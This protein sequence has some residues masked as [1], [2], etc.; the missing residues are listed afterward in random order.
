M[1]KRFQISII[2]AVLVLTNV[3]TA[4]AQ[5]NIWEGTSVSHRVELTPYLVKG[6]TPAPAVIVCPGGSYFWHDMVN[7]GSKVAEWLNANGISAFVLRY[8]TAYVPAFITHFRLLFRG[9]RYPDALNDLRQSLRLVKQQAQEYNIDTTKIGVMG[10]SAGGHLVMSAV[11]FLPRSEWP[12]FVVPVY[13]VVSFVDPCVHKRSRRGLLGDSREHNKQLCDSLSLERHVPK[14]CPPVFLIN[15][16]DD[17][18]VN[19]RN[20]ELLDSALTAKNVPHKFIQ[21]K[22]GGHGF[23]A[24]EKKGSAECRQWKAEFIK[25][26]RTLNLDNK[27]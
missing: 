22:T 24:S 23:G 6:N 21:Y 19:H 11:E 18:I 20:A 4:Q 17:P 27:D 12:A 8:R 13:P 26:F 5:I 1:F 10:F 7:E 2:I 9:N 16:K 25:W 3:L 14:D 15:C